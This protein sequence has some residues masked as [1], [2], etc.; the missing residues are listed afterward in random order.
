MGMQVGALC[1]GRCQ[2]DFVPGDKWSGMAIFDFD[3][4]V[5]ESDQKPERTFY[6]N[7]KVKNIQAN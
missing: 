3:S 6:L 1:G 2:A 7:V 4:Y 5:A